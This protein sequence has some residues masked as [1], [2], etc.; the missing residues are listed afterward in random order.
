M[1]AQW[2]QTSNGIAPDQT[3]FSLEKSSNFLYAGVAFANAGIGD[4]VYRSSDNGASWTILPLAPG[5][6]GLETYEVEAKGSTIFIGTDYFIWKSTNSG[7]TWQVPTGWT[8]AINHIETNG[9]IIY[10]AAGKWLYVS[11]D[12]GQNYE[13]RFSNTDSS[14]FTDLLFYNG[15][16]Y[17]SVRN[18]FSSG[19]VIRTADHGQSWDVLFT[20]NDTMNTIIN[21]IQS[22]AIQGDNIYAG[23]LLS[24]V[25]ASHDLGLNW[26]QTGLTQSFG[27][28]NAITTNGTDVIAGTLNGVFL[29]QDSGATW[30]GVN[31]GFAPFPP[32]ANALCIHNG[33]LF[34]GSIFSTVWRCDLNSLYAMDIDEMQAQGIELYPNPANDQLYISSDVPMG[35]P[36]DV[37][38]YCLMG[39]PVLSTTLSDLTYPLDLSG[40]KP[41]VYVAE[42]NTQKGILRKKI[43]V[44]AH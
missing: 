11:F 10:G 29:S 28:I 31:N 39:V 8:N 18:G 17:A 26:H 22:L 27:G 43:I 19:S 24:G 35:E 23:S 16:L 42:I 4:G 13:Q 21:E 34:L 30:V 36:Y 2:V 44:N 40:I 33:Y 1:P 9:N 15:Y 25:Y 12:G 38:L 32:D 20:V 41:G 7:N 3:V 14:G 6:N 5:N 37:S